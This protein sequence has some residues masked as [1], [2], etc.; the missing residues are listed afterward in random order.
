MHPIKVHLV[1][2]MGNWSAGEE[3]TP[4]DDSLTAI[5]LT[6]FLVGARHLRRGISEIIRESCRLGYRGRNDI[7]RDRHHVQLFYF[8]QKFY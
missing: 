8:R 7:H 5:R 4:A 3:K 1:E 2:I 6:R